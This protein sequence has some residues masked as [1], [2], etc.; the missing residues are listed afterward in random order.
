MSSFACSRLVTGGHGLLRKAGNLCGWTIRRFSRMVGV[1]AYYAEMSTQIRFFSASPTSPGHPRTHTFVCHH[2]ASI[3]LHL[4]GKNKSA[5]ENQVSRPSHLILSI[6]RYTH[7][8][9]PTP[10]SCHSENIWILC[11]FRK[12]DRYMVSVALWYSNI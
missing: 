10:L 7:T 12:Q 6:L 11:L 1:W 5:G 3:G 8:H 4:E 2:E 9:T